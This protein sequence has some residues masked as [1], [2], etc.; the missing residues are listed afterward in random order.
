M[1]GDSSGGPLSE[2]AAE[3]ESER[4]TLRE[5]MAA[6][7]LKPSPLKTVI[8]WLGEKASRMKLNGRVFGRSPLSR[9]LELE[10]LITGV[11]GKLQLWRALAE[12]APAD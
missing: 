11:S 7:D 9:L 6:L 1:S 2:I 10:L 3:I 12:I 5:L 8:G 4:R